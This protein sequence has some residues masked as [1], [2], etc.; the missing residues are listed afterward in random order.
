MTVFACTWSVM[1][2][3]VPGPNDDTTT[4]FAR[5]VKWMIINL[6]FPEFIFSKAVC[7]LRL[8]IE[9][10][11]RF[12]SDLDQAPSY[13]TSKSLQLT[14]NEPHGHEPGYPRTETSIPG[15]KAAQL[16]T[17]IRFFKK[18]KNFINT[19]LSSM[20]S[21]GL[22]L[23]KWP[24]VKRFLKRTK[25][26]INRLSLSSTLSKF[27]EWLEAPW[28]EK[29]RESHDIKEKQQWTLQHSYYS[30]MGGLRFRP[31]LEGDEHMFPASFL[32]SR[33]TG[34]QPGK[35][36]LTENPLMYLVLAKEDI[37][38]KSKTDWVTKGIA[39]LQVTRIILNVILRDAIGLPI[40]QMEIATIAFAVMAVFIYLVNWW[41]P[42][43]VSR[44]TTLLFTKYNA[45]YHGGVGA[46]GQSMVHRIFGPKTPVDWI[47]YRDRVP[48]D[49]VSLQGDIPLLY[50][51]MA[52]SSLVFGGLHC[53]AWKTVFPTIVEMWC[54]RASS[55]VTA[56]L[57]VAALVFGVCGRNI[58]GNQEQSTEIRDELKKAFPP[59][60]AD[61]FPFMERKVLLSPVSEFKLWVW[62]AQVACV[63]QPKASRNWH[64]QLP[65]ADIE[66]LKQDRKSWREGEKKLKQF[67]QIHLRIMEF[68]VVLDYALSEANERPWELREGCR[69]A[70]KKL[71][72]ALQYPL[73]GPSDFWRDFEEMVSVESRPVQANPVQSNPV[74]PSPMGSTPVDS[75]PVDSSPVE[76]SAV[77]STGNPRNPTLQSHE[78]ADQY[79][80]CAERLVKAY[81][82]ASKKFP[83]LE[84]WRQIW[85]RT[86][87][88][89]SIFAIVIYTTARVIVIVLLFTTLRKVPVAVYDNT[90]WTRFIPNV[91]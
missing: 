79:I 45:E 5:K 58:A 7:D 37:Q 50:Y 1:H 12:K 39:I 62:D 81:D 77:S 55:L 70:C 10:W 8:A 84:P 87:H 73:K 11:H 57:P 32:T 14:A 19:I 67:F 46:R 71:K 31:S 2:L 47:K 66:H 76:S 51:L 49:F 91:S 27:W 28:K 61:Q 34:D 54:W 18:L 72:K 44:S 25:S 56:A 26:V 80:T 75:I 83:P 59:D 40:T 17:V 21:K 4:K 43:G 82:H 86:A 3:N 20:L 65:R 38:D 90:T 89:V 88:V 23:P 22:K 36:G 13:T 42:Q 29:A 69:I 52:G 16:P 24:T 15:W 6:L 33:G 60:S 63:L 53:L 48:N 35:G 9:D 74:E 78:Q 68:L 30:Q 64:R 41:K 85:M